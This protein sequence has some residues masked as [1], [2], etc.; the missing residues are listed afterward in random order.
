MPNVVH[1]GLTDAYVHQAALAAE[2]PAYWGSWC[3]YRDDPPPRRGTAPDLGFVADRG[4][5]PSYSSSRGPV[6]Q[7]LLLR[8]ERQDPSFTRKSRRSE[9]RWRTPATDDAS[10]PRTVGAGT[11]DERG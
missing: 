9:I 1:N 8:T 10:K 2:P 3:R 5:S 7:T 4:S 6:E 11:G